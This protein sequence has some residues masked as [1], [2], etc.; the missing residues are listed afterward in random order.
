MNNAVSVVIPVY[1][2]RENLKECL[3]S[4]FN[5][6][7]KN[8]DVVVVDDGSRDNPASVAKKFP[9]KITRLD[10]DMGQAYARNIGVKESIGDIILFTDSDCLVMKDWVKRFSVELI[11]A[12]KE[13]EDIV[14]VCGRLESGD[15]FFEKCNA[16]AGYAY[17]QGGGRKF[18]DYL[19][20]ACVAIY[21]EVFWK[22]GGFSE[23]MR[24]SED[25]D[26]ALKLV[27]HGYKVV[28]EPSISVFHN[29][30][31]RTFKDF[32]LKHKEWG[33]RLGLKLVLKHKERFRILLP[34]LLNPFTHFFLIIPAAF[35]TTI[36]IIIYNIKFDKKILMY[37]F[38]IFLSKIFFR[39]GIF[40]QSAKK[41]NE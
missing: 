22:V 5:T 16:Y 14:A 30:G 11:R 2:D 10:K 21:K 41:Y 12:H 6:E 27:E 13:S 8:F 38:F 24:T 31:I 4:L 39:W 33:S 1:N 20:T 36:K 23:D 19:N 9:C 40:I 37:A 35:F 34:L 28:F 7:H 17:I 15:S 29:H 3:N 18:M 25:P 26:L 32:I